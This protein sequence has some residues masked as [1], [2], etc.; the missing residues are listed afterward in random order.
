MLED[1]LRSI[2]FIHKQGFVKKGKKTILLDFIRFS[3]S[4]LEAYF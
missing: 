2:R 3:T 4:L 1:K